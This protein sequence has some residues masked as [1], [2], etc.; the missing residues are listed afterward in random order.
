[1]VKYLLPVLLSLGACT[2]AA[3]GPQTKRVDIVLRNTFDHPIEVRA[4][5]GIFTRTIPLG[6]GQIWKGWIPTD[7]TV[8]EV[9]VEVAE[10]SRLRPAAVR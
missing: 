1:M 8:G 3:P 2:S 7:L 6:P 10:D 9:L 5:V 4:S